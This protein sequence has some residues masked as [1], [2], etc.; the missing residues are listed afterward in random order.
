MRLLV[1]IPAKNEAQDIADVISSIPREIVGVSG[2]DVLVIDDNSR[3]GTVDSAIRAGA[4]YIIEKRAQKGLANSFTLGTMFFLANNYDIL[5]NTDGD[6]QYYQE[7]I[8]D[9]IQP[10]INHTADLAIGDRDYANLSHFSFAKKTF[11]RIGSMVISGVSGAKVTDAAS[12]FRAYSRG[13]VSRLSVTTKFSYAMETLIQAGHSGARI[14]SLKTGAKEVDRPSRLFK[15]NFEHIRKSSQAILRGLVTY[16]PLITFMGLSSI[17]GIVG[18]VPF[19]RYLALTLSGT[20]GDHIQ[21]LIL[22][23]ILLSGAFT[24][25]SL[26]VLSDLIRS[27]RI[28]LESKFAHDRLQLNSSHL[29]GLLDYW[30]ADLVFEKQKET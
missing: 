3:D 25:A 4:D 6:N 7:A 28:V 2:V 16:R 9:L 5:V 23:V 20:P 17:L 18:M 8:P 13:L 26:A 14:V 22:G 24:A 30:D 19:V 27:Q 21:S 11:Q 10:L 12:G 1:Q 15:S 29:K